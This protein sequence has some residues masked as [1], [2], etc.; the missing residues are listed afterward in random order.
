[1]EKEKF[2]EDV[3]PDDDPRFS[4][5][6]HAGDGTVPTESAIGLFRGEVAAIARGFTTEA[7]GSA[8]LATGEA[9]EATGEATDH[10][11]LMSN[12]AVQVR[13]LQSLGIAALRE[14]MTTNLDGVD[15]GD[16]G[17]AI[18]TFRFD[19]VEGFVRDGL[20]R[21][22]GW[23]AATGPL[24]EIPG[25]FF[26]G[27]ENGLGWIVGSVVQPLTLEVSGQGGPHFV[28]VSVEAGG[29]TGGTD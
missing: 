12:S 6:M 29:F 21:R 15:L 3:D 16:V 14:D 9:T 27:G 17:T 7:T 26:F 1:M 22:L 19:P 2:Y 8:T 20:G 25:S 10:T 23:T 11:G 5:E 13:I 4:A 24:E 28:D 18:V